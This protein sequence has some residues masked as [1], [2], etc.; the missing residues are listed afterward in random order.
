MLTNW[1]SQNTLLLG[2][3][4]AG[5]TFLLVAS[6]IATPWIVARL[7]RDYLLQYDRTSPRHPLIRLLINTLRS[8]IGLALILL[9]LLMIVIPGPG[10]ITL[11]IGLSIARFPGKRQLLRYL[12]SRSSVFTSLNWM[13]AR[14]G[15]AP[16][17][18][19]HQEEH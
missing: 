12:A 3:L 13:R 9:G 8:V 4:A 10:V 19:P 16:L 5:S 7:P 15:Q 11:L 6:I 18:H 2:L 1:L 17:L 14:Q